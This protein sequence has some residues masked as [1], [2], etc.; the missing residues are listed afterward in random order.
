VPAVQ[1][2]ADGAR[3]LGIRLND[4]QLAAFQTYYELLVAWN[5]RVN[6]TRITE[7]EAVQTKH[8]LDSLSCLAAIRRYPALSA[9]MTPPE[10]EVIDVGSGAG[11]P[12]LP[13]KIA[14]PALRLTLLEATAKKTAFLQAAVERLGLSGVTVVTARAEEAGQ[15]PARREGCDLV[16]ARALA[17]MAVLAELTLPLARAGG[18]VVAQKGE[19]PAAEV[20]A[21][22]KAI[23]LLGGRVAEV[24]PVAV[25]GLEAARHLVVLEKI[26]ATPPGYPRRPGLPAKRPLA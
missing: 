15:D 23:K 1:L 19:D 8:F 12:G 25:P 16:V 11:F 6:L 4:D 22:Q 2:L 26:A 9:G 20:A 13:L 24:L 7:F 3:A 5:A 14:F 10:L 18:W 21:A 17:D